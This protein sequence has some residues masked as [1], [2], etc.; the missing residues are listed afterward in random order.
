[1]MRV[2]KLKRVMEVPRARQD[3]S[4]STCGRR[5]Q[6]RG[7]WEDKLDEARWLKEATHMETRTNQT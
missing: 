7:E 1:M 5:K 3:S 2:E 4:G 6:G